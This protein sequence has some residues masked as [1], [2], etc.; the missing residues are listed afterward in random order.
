MGRQ[1]K[2]RPRS[3]PPG[4]RTA[5][6]EKT[7]TKLGQ[8]LASSLD[9][10]TIFQELARGI[11]NRVPYDWLVIFEF[12]KRNVAE[13][14]FLAPTRQEAPGHGSPLNDEEKRISQWVAKGKKTFTWNAKR[15]GKKDG[16]ERLA[17]ADV[18]SYLGLPLIHQ[19]RVLGSL[20][21]AC[22][23]PK[24]YGAAE[25]RFLTSVAGW[26]ALA[27]DKARVYEK[28]KKQNEELRTATEYKSQFLA[29]M[30]HEIRTPLGILIGFLDIFH[31][32]TLGPV[33]EG[34]KTALDKM[35]SQ[36]YSLQKMINDVLSL[37]RIEEGSI[38]LEISTFSL[39]RIIEPLRT[40]VN[41]LQRKSRLKVLWDIAPEFPKLTS[42]AP[43]LEEILQNLIVNAFKYTPE[44]EIR[45]RVK[46]N[47]EARSVKFV[48]ED[49]G[50]G[51]SQ[52]DLPKIFEG[53]R[54]VDATT[55]SQGVGLGL[56]IVK[57][58]LDLINGDIEV[59]T[60]PGKG[61]IFKVTLPYTLEG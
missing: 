37:S 13:R 40:L 60:Q 4:K 21:L 1:V 46:N 32:G 42:D 18:G 3:K 45:I 8:I 33:N 23:R 2:Q 9:L 38:P 15:S 48:V 25:I 35:Q 56:T 10:K 53:F 36:S 29:R 57:K 12:H 52:Q 30:S 41:D 26:L 31:S 17:M 59:E 19:G 7:V 61:S 39:D 51:I 58:Y 5:Q 44:G 50:L 28:V 27:I 49:T 16:K 43:K 11:K 34:Q 22:K 47:P 6:S 24:A 20:H 55:S 54:Q 14:V